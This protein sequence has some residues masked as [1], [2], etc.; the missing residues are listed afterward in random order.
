MT[1]NALKKPQHAWI[2]D[3]DNS[4][5]IFV[6]S[7]TIKEHFRGAS[8]ELAPEILALQKMKAEKP[9]EFRC[10]VTFGDHKKQIDNNELTNPYEPEL[11]YFDNQV[12]ANNE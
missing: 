4:Y 2:R 3:I 7:L 11:T 10:L 12:K 5:N 8:G 9:T 6:P 1:E